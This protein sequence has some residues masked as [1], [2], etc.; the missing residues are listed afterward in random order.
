MTPSDRR[1]ARAKAELRDK[2]RRDARLGIKPIKTN[3]K[4]KRR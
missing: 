1:K 2:Q 3:K 4:G